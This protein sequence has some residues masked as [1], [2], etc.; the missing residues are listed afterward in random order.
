[1]KKLLLAAFLIPAICRA[2]ENDIDTVRFYYSGV[3]IIDSATPAK[4]LQSRARIFITENFK[5]AR[6]VIQMD[7][8]D[9]GVIIVKAVFAP[10]AKMGILGSREYGWVNFMLKMQFKDGKYKYTFSDFSHEGSTSNGHTAFAGGTL[11]N[12][13]PGCGTFYMTMGYWRQVKQD[14]CEEE[15]SLVDRIEAA[16]KDESVSAKKDSF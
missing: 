15:R 6:D 8:Q 9:A 11:T 2:Q 1:M 14:A 13:K 4:I 3:S 12:I 7:D 5:S 16:M 10:I